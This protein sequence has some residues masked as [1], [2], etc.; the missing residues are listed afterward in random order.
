[1]EVYIFHTL[2]IRPLI[3]RQPGI[4]F[5]HSPWLQ[6]RLTLNAWRSHSLITI[7]K[8]LPQGDTPPLFI[9]TTLTFTDTS[10]CNYD[11][12][13]PQICLQRPLSLLPRPIQHSH[14]LSF[15]FPSWAAGC[16]SQLTSGCCRCTL[17]RTIR[18][19]TLFL[20][21]CYATAMP[22]LR[23]D[24]QTLDSNWNGTEN[25]HTIR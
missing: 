14:R 1:M 2:K 17:C 6:S 11:F 13:R 23:D 20:I 4:H 19:G 25:V 3:I 21:G 24:I 16:C 5:K 15:A 22:V 12:L 9:C 10:L 7:Y 18:P 8:S